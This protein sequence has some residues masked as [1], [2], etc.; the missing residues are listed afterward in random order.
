MNIFLDTYIQKKHIFFY[1][2]KCSAFFSKC[3]WLN[4]LILLSFFSHRFTCSAMVMLR[5][6]IGKASYSIMVSSYLFPVYFWKMLKNFFEG[7]IWDKRP[8][9]IFVD[10]I[11]LSK[12]NV[13][14]RSC[15]PALPTYSDPSYYLTTQV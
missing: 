2:I 4:I 10:M 15:Y 12:K 11:S 14:Y 3:M 5:G 9:E 8:I 6:K 13:W 7:D 1:I